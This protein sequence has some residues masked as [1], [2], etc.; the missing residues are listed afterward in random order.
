MEQPRYTIVDPADYD[1]LKGYQWLTK[2]G[3]N[4][5]YARRHVPPCKGQKETIVY[6]HQELITV[7]KGMVVDHINNDG[8]DNRRA[9][10][11][12]ATRAQN[13]RNRKKHAKPGASKY[14][15]VRYR[16]D[17]CKWSA[18]IGVDS[19]SI[20]LGSFENEIEA[21]KAYDEAAKKHHAEFACLNFPQ[22]T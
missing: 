4:S 5:F 1:R 11:R 9:N 10:L 12:A 18:R 3:S 21:A 22:K 13:M 7:P 15:G 20:Y 6:I 14:K 17:T 19:K 2:K 8:M 16:K